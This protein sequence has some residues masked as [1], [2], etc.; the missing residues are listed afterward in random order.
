MINFEKPQNLLCTL[1]YLSDDSKILF[2][3]GSTYRYNGAFCLADENGYNRPLNSSDINA[4][5]EEIEE[6]Q[7]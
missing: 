6:E 2:K 1:N 5:F 3:K 7:N 4:H